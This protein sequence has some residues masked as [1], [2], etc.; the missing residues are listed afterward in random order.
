MLCQKLWDWFTEAAWTA[1]LIPEPV[2]PVEWS[3]PKF[4]SV[5]PWQDAQTDVL[6]TRAGFVSLK[7]QIA[8]R[9]QNADE[10]FDEIAQTNDQLDDQSLVFD[11]DPRRVTKQGMAQS[12]PLEDP[13][14]GGSGEEPASAAQTE[15]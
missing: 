10:V 14:G 1:G 5:N 7:S 3:T 15:D 6:E 2:I 8:K 4:E 13:P 9:G 11:S 12:E